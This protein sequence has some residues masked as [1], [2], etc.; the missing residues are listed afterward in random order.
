ME[1]FESSVVVDSTPKQLVEYLFGPIR[2]QIV[3]VAF[4]LM[5]FDQIIQPKTAQEVAVSLSL[6]SKQTA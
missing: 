5:V 3:D 1:L 6:E 2:W 4:D